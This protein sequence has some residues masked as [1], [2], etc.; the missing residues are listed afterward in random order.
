MNLTQVWP[1]S[2]EKE[3]SAMLVQLTSMSVVFD[4]EPRDGSYAVAYSL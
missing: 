3:T 1:V 4:T 2:I